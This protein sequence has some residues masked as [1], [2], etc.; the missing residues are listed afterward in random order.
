MLASSFCRTGVHFA[1]SAKWSRLI[2]L[3]RGI[4]GSATALSIEVKMP[5]LSPTMSEGQIV[6]WSK[7]E[8]EEVHAG[9]VICDIQTDKAVVSLES[10]E[11][12][13]M[14]KIIQAEGS[15]TIKVGKLIAILAEDGEDWK[16]VAS[17]VGDTSSDAIA[18][19]TSDSKPEVQGEQISGGSTPGTTINM[20]ALSP[21]MTEGTIIT[22]CKKEGEK[23]EAG[24]VICEIQTDKAVVAMEAD[25]DAIL[26]KIIIPE[27]ESGV[28]IGTMICITVEE[29]EDWKDVQIPSSGKAYKP[30]TDKI[31][32]SSTETIIPQVST[33]AIHVEPIPKVGPASNLR[34]AQYGINP[35]NVTSTGP[36]GIVKEDIIR[37]ISEKNLQPLEFKE[38][39]P[40]SSPVEVDTPKAAMVTKD[41][42]IKRESGSA[43]NYT[44]IPLSTMRSVIAKR[45]VQSKQGS[46]H[47]YATAECNID[48]ISK[49]RND[50]LLSGKNWIL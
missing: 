30:T 21:T 26:A 2:G 9:D 27:N 14:A 47:G 41:K 3:N 20:P 5:S 37:H 38:T 28:K 45:L 13:V 7:K 18:A 10:D 11:D 43:T 24:D 22:W 35:G 49:I 12:G 16:E 39:T 31:K 42:A 40:A 4:K 19:T 44:D 6:Q 17:N 48:A 46:P 15:G 25:D 34:I 50:F 33:E 1:K 23:I 32:P 8:G 29:G 36:K